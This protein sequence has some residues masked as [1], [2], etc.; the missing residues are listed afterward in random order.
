MKRII[1]A[2]VVLLLLYAA[3]WIIYMTK[4]SS[5]NEE[6]YQER[7]VDQEIKGKLNSI[8][9][10]SNNPYKVALEITNTVNQTDLTYGVICMDKEFR[11]YIAVGDS[12]HK[13]RGKRF[14]LFCKSNDDCKE[15]ELVFCE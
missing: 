10:Y 14:V 6:W 5:A 2:A 15:F 8:H 7:Y 13:Q 3:F 4:L 12:I 11:D 1:L 9:E